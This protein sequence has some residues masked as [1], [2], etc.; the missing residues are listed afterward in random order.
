MSNFKV[1]SEFPQQPSHIRSYLAGEVPPYPDE[2]F[3]RRKF[4]EELVDLARS[5]SVFIAGP[6]EPRDD[7]PH[8]LQLQ[9]LLGFP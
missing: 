5:D 1:V 6:F 3:G 9:S 4:F 8:T 2:G 7:L